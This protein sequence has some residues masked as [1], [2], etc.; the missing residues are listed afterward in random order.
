MKKMCLCILIVLLLFSRANATLTTEM[1][2]GDT[3]VLDDSTGIYWYPDPYYFVGHQPHQGNYNMVMSNID[4]INNQSYFGMNSW[5]LATVAEYNA[6]YWSY[7][8]TPDQIDNNFSISHSF[9]L[10]LRDIPYEE[11]HFTGILADPVL[12]PKADYPY[13]YD[14]WEPGHY[15]AEMWFR[16][17]YGEDEY[18]NKNSGFLMCGENICGYMFEDKYKRVDSNF[19]HYADPSYINYGA[20]VVYDPNYVAPPPPPPPASTPEPATILLLGFG[21]V[22]LAGIRRKI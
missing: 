1:Y 3:A 9:W 12:A 21:L 14:I 20:W 13:T 6:L 4:Q 11:R 18:L 19:Y 17:Y 22:G 8:A 5:H 15:L 10:T 2:N 16:T 7:R